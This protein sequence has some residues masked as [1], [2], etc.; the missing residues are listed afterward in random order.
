[1]MGPMGSTSGKGRGTPKGGKS[2]IGWIGWIPKG[3]IKAACTVARARTNKTA[4][5]KAFIVGP[6]LYQD[7]K[8]TFR[9]TL[10]G[11]LNNIRYCKNSFYVM[12]SNKFRSDAHKMHTSSF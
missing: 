4:Q 5:A 10:H 6:I 12:I 2:P 7:R 9:Q 1:M 11:D 3:G 8:R